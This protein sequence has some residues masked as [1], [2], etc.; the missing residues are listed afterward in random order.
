MGNVLWW[1]VVL[2]GLVL[3]AFV[4]VAQV[5]KRFVRSDDAAG[6][7]FTLAD[8]RALHRSGKMSDE[9]FEKAKQVILVAAVRVKDPPRKDEGGAPTPPIDAN[10]PLS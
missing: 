5:K 6:P 3:V 2:I 10:R 4:A 7:G 1:S 8:L 9:E